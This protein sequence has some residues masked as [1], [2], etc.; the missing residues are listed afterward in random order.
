MVTCER[1]GCEKDVASKTTYAVP[2]IGAS[3]Y[4]DRCLWWVVKPVQRSITNLPVD[5]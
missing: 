1:C 3:Y 2:Q 5:I 4:W